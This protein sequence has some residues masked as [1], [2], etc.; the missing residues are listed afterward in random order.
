MKIAFAGGGSLGP[1][2]PLLAVYARLKER[3]PELE[4]IWFG[5]PNGPERALLSAKGI[6]FITIPVAKW[7]RF[8]S[9]ERLLFPFKYLQ[10]LHLA[11]HAL[12]RYKP[13]VVVTVGGFTA[14][15]VVRAAARLGIPCVAHQLDRLPGLANRFLVDRCARVTTSFL[16]VR[17]PFGPKV[18]T[19]QIATPVQFSLQ[20]L[21]A[22]S[23]AL[24]Q[25]GLKTT[26]PTVLVMG[27]GT[28]ATAVS[29]VVVRSW[30]SWKKRGWQVIHITGKGKNVAPINE[31]GIVQ[32][33]F[34]LPEEMLTLY[35]A[36]DVVISRAGMGSISELVTLRKPMILIPIPHPHQ[37]TNTRPFAEAGGAI[38]ISQDD[39]KLDQ[40][41]A[42]AI[43][44]YLRDTPFT[45]LTVDRAQTLLPTDRGEALADVV[46]EVVGS[47]EARS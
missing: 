43:Q 32:K 10:A 9:I 42:K 5:T 13:D 33:E 11:R 21:P 38:V 24:R 28:G 36:A 34:C 26:A 3:H 46:E 18:K 4:I 17:P 12:K 23:Q 25:L 8:L 39:P 7:P 40:W 45:R 29:D 37:E 19:K 30:P 44:K 1:V 2:T 16:Y 27:G 47:T 22:R 15:P 41:V 6:P 14:V 20:D 35:A 31:P